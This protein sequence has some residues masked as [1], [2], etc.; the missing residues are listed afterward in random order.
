M[1]N[2]LP[3]IQKTL[4]ASLEL[5]YISRPKRLGFPLCDVNSWH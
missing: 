2:E 3:W 4:L 1:G 5:H